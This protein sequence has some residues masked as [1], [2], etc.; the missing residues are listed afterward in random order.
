MTS[1]SPQNLPEPIAVNDRLRTKE[2][3]AI[4]RVSVGMIYKW[5]AEDRF[6]TW[7]VTRRGFTRG[8]RYIDKTTFE[9]FLRSHQ[10][11]REEPSG[12]YA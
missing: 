11:T 2:A 12:K 4:A 5:M 8:V 9:H 7:I 1:I 6:K 10:T 3:A